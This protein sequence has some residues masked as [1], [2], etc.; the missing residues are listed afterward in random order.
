MMTVDIGVLKYVHICIFWVQ[1]SKTLK[2]PS[3]RS[4]S[5]KCR[6]N[7]P[8]YINVAPSLLGYI[9]QEYQALNGPKL[10]NLATQEKCSPGLCEL[11]SVFVNA[12]VAF[13]CLFTVH[14]GD[15]QFLRTT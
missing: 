5:V 4:Y 2:I 11:T 7:A 15:S 14:L 13:I 8:A 3:S 10:V 6:I 1:N 9:F 12:L